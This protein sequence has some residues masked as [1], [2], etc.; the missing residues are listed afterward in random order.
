[1]VNTLDFFKQQII[2][3]HRNKKKKIN[4]KKVMMLG[5][6]ALLPEIR[7][8]FI[9]QAVSKAGPLGFYSSF[10]CLGIHRLGLY[11]DSVLSKQFFA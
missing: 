3:G 11:L 4:K 7:S 1:M 5:A 6:M 8:E 2:S 10:F 9:L